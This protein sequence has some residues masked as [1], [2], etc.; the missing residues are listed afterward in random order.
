MNHF[1]Q[2]AEQ[3]DVAGDDLRLLP[4]SSWGEIDS[5]SESQDEGGC[6]GPLYSNMLEKLEADSLS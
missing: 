2:A 3:R 6:L 4:S 1:E 5:S